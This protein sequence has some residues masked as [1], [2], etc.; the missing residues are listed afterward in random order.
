MWSIKINL[1]NSD[2]PSILFL[3]R[4]IGNWP[5]AYLFT[6]AVTE[7]LIQDE[8]VNLPIAILR[9]SVG[10]W[11]KMYWKKISGFHSGAQL[12]WK[13]VNWVTTHT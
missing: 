6:K 10:E 4:L 5:N 13:V 8:G 2:I 7:D 11:K 12:N 9:P 1:R 3:F